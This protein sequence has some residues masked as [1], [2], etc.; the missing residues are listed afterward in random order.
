M[1]LTD[2][3]IYVNLDYSTSENQHRNFRLDV[4]LELPGHGI[5]A[6]LSLIHI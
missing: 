1:N 6:V 4:E 5:T 2:N 3:E